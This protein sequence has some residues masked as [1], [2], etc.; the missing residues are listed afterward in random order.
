M[1]E[2]RK[3]SCY[4]HKAIKQCKQKG[5]GES[6]N[7]A[8]YYKDELLLSEIKFLFCNSAQTKITNTHTYV[9]NKNLYWKRHEMGG[10]VGG[11]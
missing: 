2:R 1:R 10:S 9:G 6:R 11:V 7:Y 3:T 8:K 4:S 5:K